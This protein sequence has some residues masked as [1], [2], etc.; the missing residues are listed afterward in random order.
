MDHHSL[1]LL[2]G[3]TLD[4]CQHVHHATP[5]RQR[6]QAVPLQPISRRPLRNFAEGL[7]RLLPQL[8][9]LSRRL[10]RTG[11]P[12]G[13]SIPVVRTW[14]AAPDSEPSTSAPASQ[15][16]AQHQRPPRWRAP[17]WRRVQ[18]HT[19]LPQEH[20]ACQQ[21]DAE[22]PQ[23]QLRAFPEKDE[24]QRPEQ[25]QLQEQQQV[26]EQQLQE[27]HHHLLTPHQHGLG[28][29]RR[30]PL[31]RLGRVLRFVGGRLRPQGP[32]EQD[33]NLP[34]R[35]LNVATCGMFFQAGGKIVRWVAA[36]GLFL[37]RFYRLRLR[38]RTPHVA[39]LCCRPVAPR[40]CGSLAAR[41]FGWAFV[42]VGVIAT[43]YHGSWG[44]FRL[45]ARKVDYYAIAA[46]SL[47]LRSAVVGP[48]PRWLTAA[49]LA[50]VPFKPTAV[51]G[52]NFMAVEVRY[53]LLALSQ[54]HLMAQWAA[55]TGMSLAATVCFTLDETP[56]LSWFPYTHAAFHV[57]SAAA[58]LT[59]PSALN[60]LTGPMPAAVAA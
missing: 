46:S 41:R 26:Q 60:H 58:F 25:V 32:G 23:Q 55:H 52:S 56:L 11:T 18:R 5:A 28:Q 36:V 47:L 12:T 16:H 21:Q 48:V 44:R 34:E 22:L 20:L 59:L 24:E 38:R 45:V 9:Q 33:K 30:G 57:L 19:K 13:A 42:A 8:R 10:R 4:A 17:R 40:L 7:A 31:R 51:S 37:H 1:V 39:A 2:S 54:R 15:S 27:H 3:S 29:R 49:M 43:I 6:I 35:I 53:L 50:A 14:N